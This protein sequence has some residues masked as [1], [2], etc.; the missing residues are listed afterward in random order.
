MTM[1]T[2]WMFVAWAILSTP[3]GPQPDW[4]GL[5]HVVFQTAVECEERRAQQATQP[6]DRVYVL[7]RE[8]VEIVVPLVNRWD[9]TA[10]EHL[11]L[12]SA[13]ASETDQVRWAFLSWN[14]RYTGPGAPAPIGTQKLNTHVK[15]VTADRCEQGRQRHAAL[16][17]QARRP[18]A[19]VSPACFALTAPT[20]VP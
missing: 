1:E 17:D 12:A 5:R 14:F 4:E 7:S 18:V 20:P 2:A 19:M 10:G 11:P 8:C 15:H 16:K 13:P 9:L 3:S 6:A